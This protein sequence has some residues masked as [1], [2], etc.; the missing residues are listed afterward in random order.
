MAL[1]RASWGRFCDGMATE[2]DPE[3]LKAELDKLADYEIERGIEQKIWDRER[4]KVA[5]KTLKDRARKRAEQT[6]H[7]LLLELAAIFGALIISL[8]LALYSIRDRIF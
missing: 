7:Q 1:L 8:G 3:K 6:P 2:F 4:L 5:K